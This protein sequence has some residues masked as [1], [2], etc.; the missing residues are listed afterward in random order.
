[1]VVLNAKVLQAMIVEEIEEVVEQ[2]E[3]V[4]VVEIV[5][6]EKAQELKINFEQ[7]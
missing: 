5:V 6:A 1:V 3:T 7:V 2:V 4:E